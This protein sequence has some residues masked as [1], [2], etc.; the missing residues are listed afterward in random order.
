MILRSKLGLGNVMDKVKFNDNVWVTG[1]GN[2]KVI[3]IDYESQEVI[4]RFY[5]GDVEEVFE[6]SQF[7]SFNERLNQWQVHL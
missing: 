5:N 1:F 4:C 3:V 7:D 2:G 6:T